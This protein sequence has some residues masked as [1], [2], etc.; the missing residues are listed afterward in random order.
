MILIPPG[1]DVWFPKPGHNISE[2]RPPLKPVMLFN[3]EGDP[4]EREELSDRF[5]DIVERLLHRLN[6][7]QKNA[8]PINFP[9]ND[10]K[11]DPGPTGA[12]GPWA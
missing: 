5:P 2:P 7:Y 12:W 4:E 3:I 6:Y 1:C 10:P 8:A 11:C 9:D